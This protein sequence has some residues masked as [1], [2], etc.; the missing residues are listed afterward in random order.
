MD[1]APV[2]WTMARSAGLDGSPVR[3]TT[4]VVPVSG[5]FTR[6]SSSISSLATPASTTRAAFFWLA[7]ASTSSLRIVG[8]RGDQPST[9]V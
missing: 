6:S 7:L 2:T 4:R 3:H 1:R 9:R 5:T 8:S